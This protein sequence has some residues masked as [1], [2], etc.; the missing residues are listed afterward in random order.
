[1]ALAD[2]TNRW[3]AGHLSERFDGVCQQQ[4]FGARASAGKRGF[5][6]GVSAA[7]NDHIKVAWKIHGLS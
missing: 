4:R 2:A 3:I 6:A 7:D 5:G 1:M